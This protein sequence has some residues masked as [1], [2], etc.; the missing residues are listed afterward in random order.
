MIIE[1]FH[2]TCLDILN[3]RPEQR[4]LIIINYILHE[5]YNPNKYNEFILYSCVR[6]RSIFTSE[7]PTRTSRVD[8]TPQD[9]E[10]KKLSHFRTVSELRRIN[11][12]AAPL[13]HQT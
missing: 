3:S 13:K 5:L 6:A 12:T 7:L 2:G 1:Q 8:S 10:I 11:E 4:A 9:K